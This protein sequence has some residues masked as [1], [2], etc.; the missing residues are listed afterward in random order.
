[1]VPTRPWVC[2]LEEAP[3]IPADLGERVAEL[4]ACVQEPMTTQPPERFV[5]DRDNPRVVPHEVYEAVQ[6]K[7]PSTRGT[8][9]NPHEG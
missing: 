2:D 8:K 7:F 5:I 9:E 1:M 6:R 4:R 3:P